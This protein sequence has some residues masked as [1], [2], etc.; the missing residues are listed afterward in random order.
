MA[1]FLEHL[2]AFEGALWRADIGPADGVHGRSVLLVEDRAAEAA[3]GLAGLR[4]PDLGALTAF[5]RDGEPG[6]TN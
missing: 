1:D 5:D 3:T 6:R 2:G 4:S